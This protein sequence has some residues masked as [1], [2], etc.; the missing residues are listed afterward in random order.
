MN[1]HNTM[2]DNNVHIRYLQCFLGVKHSGILLTNTFLSELNG[3]I[4]NRGKYQVKVPK[5]LINE[6]DFRQH[7]NVDQ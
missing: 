7:F 6:F 1:M 4:S 3:R 2:K 5:W